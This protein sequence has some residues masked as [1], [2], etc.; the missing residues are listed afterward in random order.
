[1][2]VTNPYPTRYPTRDA[3][4]D[5]ST[6][7][8]RRDGYPIDNRDVVIGPLPKAAPPVLGY[9]AANDP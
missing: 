8:R 5:P 6:T 9:V 3:D 4:G 1:M 2:D 7:S